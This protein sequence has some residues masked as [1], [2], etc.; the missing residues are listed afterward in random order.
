MKHSI[1]ISH[2]FLLLHKLAFTSL[3]PAHTALINGFVEFVAG[4]TELVACLA[5]LFDMLGPWVKDLHKNSSL[6]H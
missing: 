3:V 2:L 6:K 5:S 1:I 4:S